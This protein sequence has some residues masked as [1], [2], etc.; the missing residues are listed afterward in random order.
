MDHGNTVLA[1]FCSEQLKSDHERQI[2]AGV[3][4]HGGAPSEWGWVVGVDLKDRDFW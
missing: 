4:A 2:A 1:Q 3:S